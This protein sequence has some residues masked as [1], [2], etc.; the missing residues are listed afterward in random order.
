MGLSF[1]KILL[2]WAVIDMVFII[3]AWGMG[4]DLAPSNADTLARQYVDINTTNETIGNGSSAL[5]NTGLSQNISGSYSSGSFIIQP[6][7]L[8]MLWSLVSKFF[9]WAFAPYTYLTSIGAPFP[10]VLL[11]GVT[12]ILMFVM[13]IVGWIRGVEV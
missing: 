13:G 7:P 6:N 4:I 1:G 3:A 10:V 11:V 9:S 12:H 8:F 2:T 5:S